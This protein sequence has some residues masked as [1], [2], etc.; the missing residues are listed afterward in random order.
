MYFENTKQP[1]ENINLQ[2]NNIRLSILN[3]EKIEEKLHVICVLS[4]PCHYKRRIKLAE[5]FISRMEMEED[6][7]LYVVELAYNNDNYELTDKLNP[8]HLQLKASTILWHKENMINIGIKKLLPHDW[9]AVAWV[10]ADIEFD[11]PYWANNALKLLNGSYDV[12]QLFSHCIDMDNT[13]EAMNIF[14]SFCY[15]VV[16][17]E[18]MH[19]KGINFAHPG[20]AW[21]IT[22]K[23]YEKIGGLYENAILGSAD[24]IMAHAFIN[25]SS[26]TIHNNS[27]D[28]YKNDIKTYTENANKL[29]LGYVPT[30]IR[31]YYHGSK[32]N[33]KYNDRWRILLKHDYNPK[34]F[35]E[36][37][38]DII[39]SNDAQFSN[40]LKEELIN[41]FRERKE[42]E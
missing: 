4:N 6:I 15:K 27:N 14:T 39:C 19:L 5:E 3:N 29:R 34:T 8:R 21:A 40:E 37:R 33:R 17:G 42:D 18:Q 32:I 10:D 9:K 30:I 7:I 1:T 36:K 13:K 2:S 22:R 31:H 25:K 41:Y 23:A 38:D 26:T 20:F 12:L 28:G 11:G 24:N 16:K 35:L